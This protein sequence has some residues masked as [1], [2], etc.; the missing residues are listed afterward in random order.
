MPPDTIRPVAALVIAVLVTS[1]SM[2][3][4]LTPMPLVVTLNT[5]VRSITTSIPALLVASEMPLT[6]LVM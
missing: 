6:E 5:L 4:E 1:V 3:P 2:I